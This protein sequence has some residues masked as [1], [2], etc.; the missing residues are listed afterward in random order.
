[1]FRFSFMVQI[2]IL[3]TT[4]FVCVFED[5]AVPIQLVKRRPGRVEIFLIRYG[6]KSREV[7][8]NSRFSFVGKLSFFPF[9]AFDMKRRCSLF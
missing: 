6:K 2:N 3:V 1:M 5:R 9:S 4:T 7:R 8:G